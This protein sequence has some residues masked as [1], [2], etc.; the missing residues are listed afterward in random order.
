MLTEVSSEIIREM[1]QKSRTFRAKIY[2]KS[3]GE[4]LTENVRALNC[5][6][7]SSDGSDITIGQAFSRALTFSCADIGLKEDDEIKVVIALKVRSN[8]VGGDML[9]GEFTVTN[10]VKGLDGF[11]YTAYDKMYINS[12]KDVTSLPTSFDSACTAIGNLIGAP[13]SKADS[14]V[15]PYGSN[16]QSHLSAISVPENIEFKALETAG[17]LAGLV[18]C[19]AFINRN[20]NL[21]FKAQ[22]DVEIGYPLD[23]RIDDKTLEFQ[24][25]IGSIEVR[26]ARGAEDI[27]TLNRA[28]SRGAKLYTENPIAMS[29]A[30]VAWRIDNRM[31]HGADVI[32]KGTLVMKL[33]DPRIDPW[34]IINNY[35]CSTLTME[36]DGGITTTIESIAKT[37]QE[38]QIEEKDRIKQVKAELEAIQ[39]AVNDVS[40]DIDDIS[41]SIDDLG[42]EIGYLGEDLS[43][44]SGDVED[45]GNDVDAIEDSVEDIYGEIENIN[46]NYDSFMADYNRFK[47]QASGGLNSATGYYKTTQTVN[48]ATISYMHDQPK[49][50]DS[51]YIWK[52]TIDSIAVSIDGGKTYPFGM[53]VDGQLVQKY[54]TADVVN[55]LNLNAGAIK[56][57]TMSADR[58]S[59]GVLEGIKFNSLTNDSAKTKLQI[60]NGMYA[61]SGFR[62]TVNGTTYYNGLYE[63]QGAIR[64]LYDI[65]NSVEAYDG[66]IAP[67]SSGHLTFAGSYVQWIADGPNGNNE[68]RTGYNGFTG[69]RFLFLDP[70]DWTL[71]INGKLIGKGVEEFAKKADVF[72]KGKDI[73]VKNLDNLNR[74]ENCG[75][76]FCSSPSSLANYPS[77]ANG[78]LE[79]IQ[80]GNTWFKQILHVCNKAYCR[81]F[82][83]IYDGS[84]WGEWKKFDGTAV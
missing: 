78:R 40:S 2:R 27:Y 12:T 61:D 34:D 64:F 37:D 63:R 26:G 56:S 82:E 4:L 75:I 83:R 43:D 81:R 38:R 49:L 14:D 19:N 42:D 73:P 21:V 24:V 84:S 23:D 22:Q 41:G 32:N 16:S 69:T 65:V 62:R 8:F 28:N 20:G 47:E 67:L 46:A 11:D 70:I 71:E 45:L 33:G 18:G 7:A 30:D 55:A 29:A 35:A 48:G 31:T 25:T 6:A 51:T 76:Y 13:F 9:F 5:T 53:T 36:F 39:S 1:K 80:I 72:E 50:S 3:T 74:L 15:Y 77:T 17:Y 60:L 59:G 79:V 66:V 68:D 44:L 52:F 54:I 58:I 10:A 57:G